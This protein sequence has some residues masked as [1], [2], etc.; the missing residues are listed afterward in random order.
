MKLVSQDTDILVRSHLETASATIE[1]REI[2]RFCVRYYWYTKRFLCERISNMFFL[3]NISRSRTRY[4]RVLC[5][6]FSDKRQY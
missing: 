2:V 6:Q 4:S 1:S 3:P 5:Y